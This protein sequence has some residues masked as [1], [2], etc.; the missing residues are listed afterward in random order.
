MLQWTILQQLNYS[1]REIPSARPRLDSSSVCQDRALLCL[2]QQC[3]RQARCDEEFVSTRDCGGRAECEAAGA[4]GVPS[5]CQL[6]SSNSEKVN[7]EGPAQAEAERLPSMQLR[8]RTQGG[9]LISQGG[10]GGG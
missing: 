1:F 3:S 5:A 9:D 7:S 10:K 4:V 6:S 2:F 8:L